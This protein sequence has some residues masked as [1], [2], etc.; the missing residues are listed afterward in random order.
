MARVWIP[1]ALRSLTGGQE[2]VE[3][4][5][6]RLGDVVDALESQFPG[7]RARLVQ[8][9]RLRPGI[10]AVVDGEVA[11]LGLLQPVGPDSEVHFLPALSGG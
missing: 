1:A 2:C 10:A 7:T 3:L 8:G 4:S 11:R 5:G 9:D 6:T